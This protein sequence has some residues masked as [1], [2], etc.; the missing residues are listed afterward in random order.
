LKQAITGF[1]QWV[2]DDWIAEFACAL[3][4]HAMD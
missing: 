4:K 3:A 2:A 1:N